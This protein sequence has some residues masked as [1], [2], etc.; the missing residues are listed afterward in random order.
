MNLPKILSKKSGVIHLTIIIALLAILLIP[1]IIFAAKFSSKEIDVSAAN[2]INI[3]LGAVQKVYQN[4]VP[5]TDKNGNLRTTYDP[6]SSFFPNGIYLMSDE[7]KDIGVVP[8]LANAGFNLG[9]SAHGSNTDYF[10]N[11]INGTTNY[12]IAISTQG[13]DLNLLATAQTQSSSI[14]I[15]DPDLVAGTTYLYL[16][17]A[18]NCGEGTLIATGNVTAQADASGQGKVSLSWDSGTNFKIII[19]NQLGFDSNHNYDPSTFNESLFQSYKNNPA[20]FGW[21]LADEPYNIAKITGQNPQINYN[22]VSQSYNDH[23]DQ[24][25]Q[26]IFITESDAPPID[27]TWNQFVSLTDLANVYSYPKFFSRLPINSFE[28]TANVVKSIVNAVGSSKPV[29]FTSQAFTGGGYVYPTPA[30][31]KAYIYTSLIHGTTGLTHFSWDSCLTRT[32]STDDLVKIAGVRTNIVKA[33]SN[34]AQGAKII[35]DDELAGARTL[36]NA[37]DA[38]ANGINKQIQDLTPVLLSKTLTTPYS[39]L[40]DQTPISAAPIRTLLKAYNGNYYL[41]AVNIDNAT[42]NASF[43]FPFS[44]QGPIERMF[45]GS[46]ATLSG[47]SI[48]DS[49]SPFAVHIYRFPT[50]PDDTDL[51]TFKNTVENTIGTDPNSNCS[52]VSQTDAFP[53]DINRDGSVAISDIQAVSASFGKTSSSPDWPLHKRKDMN[54]D[55]AITIADILLVSKFFGKA[56]CP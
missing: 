52:S 4:G 28:T 16:V 35:N 45:E 7:Q 27:S 51:D 3:T 2:S 5:H 8:A 55:G 12:T 34:C 54:G 18:L 32:I 25:T 11:Q 24:T 23:K 48:N 33:H 26:P 17:C 6:N 40:V 13:T 50:D 42:I 30:E 47:S 56:F 29:W 31:M 21:W 19:D 9:F 43:Q 38:K 39:V 10:L 53:P 46:Q 15:T 14:E 44:L 20:V 22:A 49:F 1:L 37:L 41:L 36:W